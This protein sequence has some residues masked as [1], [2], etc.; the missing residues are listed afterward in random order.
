[1]KGYAVITTAESVLIKKSL[2]ELKH[3]SSDDKVEIR[4]FIDFGRCCIIEGGWFNRLSVYSCMPNV[5]SIISNHNRH[6]WRKGTNHL[7]TKTVIAVQ[8]MNA[9]LL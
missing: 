8:E 5:K 1:M 6:H 2:V 4:L 3:D 7:L 9:L